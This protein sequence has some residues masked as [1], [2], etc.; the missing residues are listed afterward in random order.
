[1]RKLLSF[2]S[3]FFFSLVLFQACQQAPQETYETEWLGETKQEIIN[4]IEDQFQGFSRT[5]M[6]VGYRYKE[7]YWAGQDG[8]WEYAEYQ[9]EHI[10]EAMQEGFVRR[11]AREASSQQFMSV[12]IP[13]IEQIVQD[14]DKE[15]FLQNF[16]RFTA[17]CNTCHAM[18]E[19]AFMI[20]KIP[21]IRTSVIHY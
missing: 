2:T 4:T 9:I 18:E 19:V 16:T 12:A 10:E 17:S 8:N 5:M 20:V 7:L 13:E 21:E 14:G 1:M 15:R 6:E 11:P 3:L